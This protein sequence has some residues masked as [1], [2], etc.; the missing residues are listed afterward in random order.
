MNIV[1]F[2]TPKFASEILKEISKKNTVLPFVKKTNF[3]E[4]MQ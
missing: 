2:G 1:F 3:L 4:A